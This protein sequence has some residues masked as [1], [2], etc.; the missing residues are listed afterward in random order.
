M[1]DACCEAGQRLALPPA[2]AAAAVIGVKRSDARGRCRNRHAWLALER[3]GGRPSPPGVTSLSPRPFVG[4]SWKMLAILT[5][6]GVP[7]GS[8]TLR[9][10]TEAGVWFAG[11]RT[12]FIVF[13]LRGPQIRANSITM[14][15]SRPGRARCKAK[16]VLLLP[17][18]QRMTVPP[19]RSVSL[20]FFHQMGK[21]VHDERGPDRRVFH[22]PWEHHA[23]IIV[24][25][26][27]EIDIY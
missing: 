24:L 2:G 8:V 15:E 5:V 7:S 18:A 26:L 23:I 27:K 4:S 25:I 13:Y 12:A 21:C 16:S 10:F 3:W 22:L 11:Q 20:L 9:T 14:P 17:P 6:T 1:K 19:Q